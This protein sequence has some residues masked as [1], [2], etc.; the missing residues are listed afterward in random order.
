MIKYFA[1][2]YC[3]DGTIHLKEADTKEACEERLFNMLKDK[4]V[5]DKTERTTII[6]RDIKDNQYLFGSPNSL[7]IKE[8]FTK[9]LKKN[10]VSFTRG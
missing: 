9:A 1:V 5:Y 10:K 3:V 2:I 6:K 7:N 4:R 8:K